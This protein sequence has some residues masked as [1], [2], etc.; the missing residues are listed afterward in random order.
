MKDLTDV[1]AYFIN[2]PSRP[3]RRKLFENQEALRVMPPVKH[4]SG[5]QGNKLNV[6]SDKRIGLNTRV[7]VITEYRRSHYEIHSYGALGASLSH[8]AA[9]KEFLKSDSPYALIME[10]DAEL[11]PTFP[12][13]V[14]DCMKDLPDSW[15]IW[16]LGWNHSPKDKTLKTG[17]ITPFRE[18]LQFAGAHCYIVKRDVAKKLVEEALPVET[19]VEYYMSN[20]ALIHGLKIIRHLDLCIKQMDRKKNISDVRKPKGCPVCVVDDKGEG[21]KARE[22]NS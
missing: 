9:W 8:L 10:D 14:K 15:D 1:K 4:V 13:M 5:V 3:D 17:A 20:V 22:A 21:I 12:L 11:P 16:L 7:Q 18:V 19:H 2:L 6:Y